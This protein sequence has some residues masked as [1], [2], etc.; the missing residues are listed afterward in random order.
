M[1]MSNRGFSRSLI[2]NRHSDFEYSIWWVSYGSPKC[3]NL[4]D[5]NERY[6]SGVFEVADYESLFEISKL[7][8]ADQN[9]K[10]DS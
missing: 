10:I 3:K 6:Y 9:V 2:K 5:W 1:K 4:L 8:M 7:N